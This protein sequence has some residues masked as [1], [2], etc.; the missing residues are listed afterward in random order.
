MTIW[1]TVIYIYDIYI[2]DIYKYK[3][4]DVTSNNQFRN[5]FAVS[6]APGQCWQ[7]ASEA[8]EGGAVADV[9]GIEHGM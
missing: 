1:Q 5:H 6:H 2:Y 8:S 3:Y 7:R 9:G 4:P